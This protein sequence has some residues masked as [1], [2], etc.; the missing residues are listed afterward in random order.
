MHFGT[1]VLALYCYCG[2]NVKIRTF[3]T[4]L[5]KKAT[6][7]LLKKSQTYRKLNVFHLLHG[8][9]KHSSKQAASVTCIL[10]KKIFAAASFEGLSCFDSDRVKKLEVYFGLYESSL[11]LK[12]R[13]NRRNAFYEK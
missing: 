7:W 8:I 9:N 6:I 4:L 12:R 13:D 1:L 3:K 10:E 2:D 5:S 11:L